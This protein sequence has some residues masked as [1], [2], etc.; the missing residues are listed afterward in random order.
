MYAYFKTKDLPSDWRDSF[1]IKESYSDVS[2]IRSYER[3][4]PNPIPDLKIGDQFRL[5]DDSI[6]KV[7]YMKGKDYVCT[8]GNYSGLYKIKRGQVREAKVLA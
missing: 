8:R 7:E 4:N 1:D 2:P 3:F 5:Y 6:F